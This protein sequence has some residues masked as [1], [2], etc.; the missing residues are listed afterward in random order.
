MKKALF[1][2]S[3]DPITLG[4]FEIIQRGCSMFDEVIVAIGVNSQKKYLFSLEERMEMLEKSFADVNGVRTDYY[5]GLTVEYA[6]QNGAQFLLR[7]I[8]SDTD[9][10]YERPVELINKHLYPDI[11]TIYLFS[12]PSHVHVSS[13][14]VR[15]VIKYRGK[16]EGLVPPAIVGYIKEKKFV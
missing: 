3:F 12:R 14:L 9:L 6:K 4:H 1:P 16:V 15:E 2:G 8:R 11:E 13:T 7:G 10:S 5:T